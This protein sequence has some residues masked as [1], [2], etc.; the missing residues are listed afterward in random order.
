MPRCA[1]PQW[2]HPLDSAGPV[3]N[4]LCPARHYQRLA[5]FPTKGAL[6]APRRRPRR[7]LVARVGK[8]TF[9][10]CLPHHDRR[11]VHKGRMEL[12][13]QRRV[14]HH[15]TE[16]IRLAS[17]AAFRQFPGERGR[18]MKDMARATKGCGREA[19]HA[20]PAALSP[21]GLIPMGC[22]RPPAGA[23]V[24]EC[25]FPHLAP[26]RPSTSLRAGERVG[27]GDMSPV[28]TE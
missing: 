21:R 17:S 10:I 11:H 19:D 28:A 27:S 1:S 18:P 5:G 4:E 20:A 12:L 6:G 9:A 16:R 7:L 22:I 13:S 25:A 24:P 15:F 23:I 2:G 3:P 26:V 8:E 14:V